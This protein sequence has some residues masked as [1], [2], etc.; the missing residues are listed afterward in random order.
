M[1]EKNEM[2]FMDLGNRHVPRVSAFTEFSALPMSWLLFVIHLTTF[3]SPQN[4]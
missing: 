2:S 1:E 4:I 3:V